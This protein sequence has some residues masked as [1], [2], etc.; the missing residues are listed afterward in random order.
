MVEAHVDE[1]G[2]VG[3]G[4]VSERHVI[5]LDRTAEARRASRSGSITNVEL[6]GE[7]GVDPFE[8]HQRARVRVRH[9]R[10]FANRLVHLAQVQQEDD[11]RTGGQPTIED[12]TRAEPEDRRAPHGDDDLDG[13]RQLRFDVARPE[14]RLDDP[15]AL[16]LE[17]AA[18]VIFSAERF[19]EPHRRQHLVHRR[20]EVRFPAAHV[21]R[22]ALDP[23]RERVDDDA[24]CRQDRQRDER[25]APVEIEHEASHADQQ[26]RVVQRVEDARGDRALY[27]V[28]IRRRRADDVTRTLLVVERHR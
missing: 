14:R 7:E 9:L 2:P 4:P 1:G 27:R 22:G 28:D 23:A 13:R 10:Q 11:E 20:H 5:E 8:R 17:A 3:G 18:L 19:H 12:V 24:E 26:Q 15:L 21:E 6:D 16:V 25:E